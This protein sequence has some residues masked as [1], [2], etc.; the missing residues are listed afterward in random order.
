MNA[1]RY[2]A[3]VLLFVLL[4]LCSNRRVTAPA[5]VV[6]PPVQLRLLFAGDVMQHLPQVTAAR[7]AAGFDYAPVFAALRPR[8]DSADLVV[9]NLETTLTRAEPYTGYPRFRSPAV[10][11]DALR[12]AGVD[13]AVMANNHCCDG[14]A[15]GVRTTTEKL[16][17]CGILR[18]GVFTDSADRAAHHPLWLVRR[19]I[20]I[21]LLNYTYS[22]NGI[23]V[24][25]GIAVNRID[26]AAMAADVAEARRRGAKCVAVCIH[27]GNEYERTPNAEQRAIAGSLRRAGADLIIGSH[28]HVIQTYEVDSTHVLFYSLG[29]FVSN[30]RRRYCD[31]GLMAAVTLTQHPDGHITY[32]AEA[33]PVWVA[34]PGYRILPIDVADTMNLPEA[35]T[36]FRSDQQVASLKFSGER[37]E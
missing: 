26:T 12:E 7:T 10:L 8:F 24:P 28:P 13:V 34:L 3:A 14:D 27:W 36:L 5:D 11:A 4:A 9:V 1:L 15:A 33:I 22:T 21:A 6:K 35:Y 29:N 17:S 23:P 20:P 16:D 18:T 31:G 25:H 37:R 2:A 19:Q 30:Q 32:A